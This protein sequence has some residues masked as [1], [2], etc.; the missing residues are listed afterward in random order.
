MSLA[1]LAIGTMVPDFEYFWH[2]RPLALWGHSIAGLFTFDLA[3]GLAVL[4]LWELF[5][6]DGAR[7]FLGF[8]RHS[9]PKRTVSWWSLAAAGIVIGAA[10]HLAWDGLSHH[11]NWGQR[12]FPV[13]ANTAV[14]ISGRDLAW[15]TLLDYIGTV[16]G[17]I[18]VL[19]WLFARMRRENALPVFLGSWTRLVALA[20]MIAVSLAAGLWNGQRVDV[21]G[22][23]RGELW[24]GRVAVGAM[25]AFGIAL[26]I[27]AAFV[28]VRGEHRR[29]TS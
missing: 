22:F 18:V 10:T 21:K 14:E 29:P 4:A 7:A 5:V 19:A 26:V 6:R 11:S 2:L 15:R 17:G 1:A 24:I 3:V 27:L 23:W 8:P 12:V 16:V 9:P 28:A 20:S 25:L 13:L